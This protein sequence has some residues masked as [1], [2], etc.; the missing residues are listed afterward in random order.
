[1]AKQVSFSDAMCLFDSAIQ[2]C[3]ERYQH[4]DT[5][6]RSVAYLTACTVLNQL[7]TEFIKEYFSKNEKLS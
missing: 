7:K 2:R 6:L 4:A 3:W 1:M 5:Y